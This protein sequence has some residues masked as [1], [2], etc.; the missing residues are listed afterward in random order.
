MKVN[1][2]K[3]LSEDTNPDLFF[4]C[5][6]NLIHGPALGMHLLSSVIIQIQV[7]VIKERGGT[8]KCT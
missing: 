6:L 5:P 7:S 8:E 2:M 4:L 1:C 3:L